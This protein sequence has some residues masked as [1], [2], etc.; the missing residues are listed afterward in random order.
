[1][2]VRN[3]RYYNN[4]KTKNISIVLVLA[5]YKDK[6]VFC[7]HKERSTYEIV[8]GH[9]EKNETMVEAARRELFEE[10][11]AICDEF[12]LLG[13]LANYNMSPIQYSA[14]FYANINKLESLPNYEMAEIKLFEK[15]PN[16]TT[17]PD[18]YERI[19]KIIGT[20]LWKIYLIIHKNI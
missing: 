13:Y 17:Y 16:N 8:G 7:R 4:L 5:R 15:F 12:K 1:M 6:W 9:I 18:V 3:I 10:S 14:L 19:L 11:G 2:S 20:K